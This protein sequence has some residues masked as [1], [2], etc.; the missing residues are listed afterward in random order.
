MVIMYVDTRT[1]PNPY[2]NDYVVQLL[3]VVGKIHNVQTKLIIITESVEHLK[4][5][6]Q[7]QLEKSRDKARLTDR[8]KMLLPGVP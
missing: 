3:N 4:L 7:Q 2:V 8:F 6:I 1:A 5:G